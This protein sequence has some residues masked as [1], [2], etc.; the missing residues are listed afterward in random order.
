MTSLPEK[1]RRG[2]R[3]H[4]VGREIHCHDLVTS[5]N[6]VAWE[7]A[8][9][10]ADEGTV[11]FAEE[12]AHGR[13][14]LGRNWWSSR[15]KGILMSVVL[16]PLKH[17]S[18]VPVTTIIGALA[19]ADAIRA[20]AQLPAMIRWPN[21][22]LIGDRKVGGILVEAQAGRRELV[23]GIGIDVAA[24]TGADRASMPTDVAEAA[25]SLSDAA[26]EDLDRLA[27][28]RALLRK[29]DRWY[30]VKLDGDFDSINQRWREL[31]ATLGQRLKLEEHGRIYEGTV[32]DIDVRFGL[33]LR[34]ER[35]AI[36]QFRGEH[37]SVIHHG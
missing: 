37:V 6:D 20:A 36:R 21:D 4:I 27:L 10:G 32:I 7:L 13:G 35:G 2:L 18:I 25:T 14:R 26:G 34:L 22:I 15:G 31:S 24:W 29:L 5:T 19:A 33:A 17:D 30:Q 3:T 8:K 1:L 16:R 9:A 12:Q 23:L 28:T 11:V